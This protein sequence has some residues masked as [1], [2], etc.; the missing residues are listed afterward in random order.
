M[1][2]TDVRMISGVFNTHA[3]VSVI[4]WHHN[5]SWP[6]QTTGASGHCFH[7]GE[8]GLLFSVAID[9]RMSSL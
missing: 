6:L 1:F 7:W 5:H 4:Q 2:K 9:D 3:S 8:G